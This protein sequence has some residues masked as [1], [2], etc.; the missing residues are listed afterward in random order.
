[1]RSPPTV[2][3]QTKPV[4]W[5]DGTSRY[6]D[7]LS[8]ALATVG[9]RV[10]VRRAAPPWPG[11]LTSL[12]RR[13]GF[14]LAAFWASYPLLPVPT[15]GSLLHVT[16]QSLATG[17][18]L[19]RPRQPVAVTVHDILPHT[20]R[21][22]PALNTLRHPVDRA[23]Y[24]LALRG[25]GRADLV[26]ADS[27][28]TAD[29]L[30]RAGVAG[31]ERIA[32]VPLGVDHELFRPVAP[33]AAVAGRYRLDAAERY[34]VYVGSEDPRKNLRALVSAIA[35]LAP[36]HPNLRLLKVGPA[37]HEGER[38]ALMR[39]AHDLGI[40][41]HV[42]F[43]GHVP[44]ADLPELYSASAA[45]VMP[46]LYEGFGLPV[47]EAMACGA[48]VVCS[49]R[50]SL[51]EVAGDAALIVEPTAEGI[52]DGLERVL[53]SDELAGTLRERGLARAATFTWRRTAELTIRGYE[54][55]LGGPRPG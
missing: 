34:V 44:N 7:A 50:T 17:I 46:S 8:D 37:H 3:V 5:V 19:A 14:D 13:G 49:S 43:L 16:G 51:P 41:E 22:D 2:T 1:V 28:Y 40:G 33:S 36:R 29:E 52:V 39:L 23:F 12:A 10:D 26:F 30:S 35:R 9:W 6:A 55:L 53:A 27:R 18:A 24:R 4:G 32:V 45:C 48:P 47:L 20:L 42:R 25:V 15:R 21:H 54:R 38:A 11:W 31:D